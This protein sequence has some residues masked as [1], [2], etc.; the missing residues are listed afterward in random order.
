MCHT[1]LVN[2]VYQ[3]RLTLKPLGLSLFIL[4][5][6]F[7]NVAWGAP[8][9]VWSQYEA[10]DIN[11]YFSPDGES[12]VQLT[13]SGTNVLAMLDRQGD[14]IWICWIDK[15]SPNNDRLHY[16]RLTSEGKI[17]QKGK[18]PETLGKLYAPSIA[19]EPSEDRVWLVWA[20]NHGRTEDLLVSYLDIGDVLS[21]NWVPPMQITAKDV[22]SANVPSIDRAVSGRAEISWSHTGPDRAQ[23]ASATVSTHLFETNRGSGRQI[24]PLKTR[25][26]GSRQ[27]RI[28][29]ITDSGDNALES[30]AWKRLTRNETALMG[31][32][33]SDSG[34]VMRVFDK[35]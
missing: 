15:Q 22:F 35:R 14:E 13:S 4:L 1:H 27:S 8:A 12:T 28:M 30:L 34:V 31:A 24:K 16:A 11:V 5:V 7:L 25:Y 23:Q 21:S 3:T 10:P 9:F 19:I 33:I 20:E 2:N 32:I 26:A 18:V 17:L 6:S 29:Y